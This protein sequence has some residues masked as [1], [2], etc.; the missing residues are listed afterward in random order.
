MKFH[1]HFSFVWTIKKG[2][3]YVCPL[4]FH[5]VYYLRITE[6]IQIMRIATFLERAGVAGPDDRGSIPGSVIDG[7]FFTISSTPTLRSTQPPI[8]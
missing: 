8:K 2:Q 6:E 7:I 1:R 3:I 4:C 5:F